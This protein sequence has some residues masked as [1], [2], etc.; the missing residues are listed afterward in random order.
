MLARY[1]S[2]LLVTEIVL[3]ATCATS[4]QQAGRG[5]LKGQV[6]TTG[7]NGEAVPPTSATVYVLF[8]SP[9]GKIRFSSEPRPLDTAGRQFSYHLNNLLAKNKELKRLQKSVRRNPQPGDADAIAGE[10][11]WSVDEAFNRTREWLAKHPDRSWQMHAVALDPRGSWLIEDLRPGSYR[12]VVRGRSAGYDADW[13]ASVD[14]VAGNI[15]SVTWTHPRF[16]R[17]E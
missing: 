16:L 9:F 8:S 17:H 5:A 10:Y 14:V 2:A 13:E 11:L 7:I 1:R 15:A 3:V 12:V 4:A 6:G